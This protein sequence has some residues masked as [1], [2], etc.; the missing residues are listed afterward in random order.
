MRIWLR[1]RANR[2]VFIAVGSCIGPIMNVN[3]V[4]VPNGTDAIAFVVLNKIAG[5]GERRSR[6][7][8]WDAE[9]MRV[10]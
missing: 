9:F 4:V 7:V 2:A 8:S 6:C 10:W 3:L 1:R 5:G